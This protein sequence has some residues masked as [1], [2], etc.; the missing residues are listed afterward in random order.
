M[1]GFTVNGVAYEGSVLCV[2]NL[3]T[4]WSPKKFS[5]I[6]AD[7]VHAGVMYEA[8]AVVVVTFGNVNPSKKLKNDFTFANMS[9]VMKTFAHSTICAFSPFFR[10]PPNV[11]MKILRKN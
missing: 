2:G 11:A 6:T 3:I 8:C 9:S 10:L 7:R 4:S 1:K 5:E